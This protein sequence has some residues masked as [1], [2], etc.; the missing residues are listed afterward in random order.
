[1]RGLT[2]R[3]ISMRQSQQRHE[4]TP[5]FSLSG[6]IVWQQLR[7]MRNVGEMTLMSHFACGRSSGRYRGGDEAYCAGD[8]RPSMPYRYQLR[9]RRCG[10]PVRI[11]TGSGWHYFVRRVA[12]RQ[13]R[14]LPDTAD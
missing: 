8:G 12:V 6:R 4:P 3:W 5:V 14:I 2:R 9:Q 1:M 11:M 10:I 7:A 13:W